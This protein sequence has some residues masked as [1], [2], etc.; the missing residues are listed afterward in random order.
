MNKRGS[1]GSK[2]INFNL[3]CIG[4]FVVK[5]S[6]TSPRGSPIYFLVSRKTKNQFN[7]ITKIAKKLPKETQLKQI[8]KKIYIKEYNSEKIQTK[9]L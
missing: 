3:N 4:K 9:M 2:K 8:L 1:N 6:A 7:I 5:C